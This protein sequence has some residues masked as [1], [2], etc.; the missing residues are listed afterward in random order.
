MPSRRQWLGSIAATIVACLWPVRTK[1][2]A[3]TPPVTSATASTFQPAPG[4]EPV[5]FTS[6]LYDCG[7]SI[8]TLVVTFHSQTDTYELTCE[9]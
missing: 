5:R 7:N 4:F 6:T 9:E 1:A 3:P 8:K 2:S